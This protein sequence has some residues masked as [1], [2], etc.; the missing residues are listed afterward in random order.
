MELQLYPQSQ[1]QNSLSKEYQPITEKTNLGYLYNL[2]LR[3]RSIS[4]DDNCHG[5]SALTNWYHPTELWQIRH[6]MLTPFIMNISAFKF[7]LI[8][9]LFLIYLCSCQ[10]IEPSLDEIA[11]SIPPVDPS[12]V[13]SESVPESST[14]TIST[15]STTTYG[16]IFLYFWGHSK[17]TLTLFCSFLTTH[18]PSRAFFIY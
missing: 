4:F 16:Q 5:K 17:T 8:Q 13:S 11:T 7:I 6:R 10:S 12:A 9:H 2:F 1:A 3:L 15:T 18:L 14:S